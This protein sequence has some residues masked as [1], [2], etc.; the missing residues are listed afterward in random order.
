MVETP[1]QEFAS[2]DSQPAKN[3]HFGVR[4]RKS[5]KFGLFSKMKTKVDKEQ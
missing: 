5:K 3:R 1:L 4:K 2:G